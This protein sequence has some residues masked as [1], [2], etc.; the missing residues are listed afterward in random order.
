LMT[1]TGP[2]TMF[3]ATHYTRYTGP[4]HR[5]R[6][7]HVLPPLSCRV[8]NRNRHRSHRGAAAPL[9]SSERCTS[10]TLDMPIALGMPIDDHIHRTSGARLSPSRVAEGGA[11][12]HHVMSV[13]G[14]VVAGPPGKFLPSPVVLACALVTYHRA[15]S[16]AKFLDI[17]TQT[18][19]CFRR[20]ACF[21][22]NIQGLD[23]RQRLNRLPSTISS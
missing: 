1:S 21:R 7:L 3:Y 2:F 17:A 10:L 12:R 18:C 6:P 15:A 22:T 19:F 13:A 8:G 23:R 14:R 20:P 9:G 4:P 16:L 5:L 11:P